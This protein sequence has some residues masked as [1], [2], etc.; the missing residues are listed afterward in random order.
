[1]MWPENQHNREYLRHLPRDE[2][3]EFVWTVKDRD[4]AFGNFDK[5]EWGFVLGLYIHYLLA[6]FPSNNS[7]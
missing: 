6:V 1:M 4:V 3:D 5:K 2:Y 7:R